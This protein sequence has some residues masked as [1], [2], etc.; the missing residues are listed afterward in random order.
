MPEYRI[1]LM[2]PHGHIES[3][4]QVLACDNNR[5]ALEHAKKL[6]DGRLF[7]VWER[8]RQ[9]TSDGSDSEVCSS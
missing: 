2:T 5:E 9:V 7:E 6:V 1:Y 8:A 4:A 3:S